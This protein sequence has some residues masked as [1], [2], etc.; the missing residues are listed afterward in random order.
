M[1]GCIKEIKAQ[2]GASKEKIGFIKSE[3]LYIK[4]FT[5]EAVE[6]LRSTY[7][8]HLRIMEHHTSPTHSA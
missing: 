7:M 1:D 6:H 5:D 3:F 2:V 4:H 8:Q